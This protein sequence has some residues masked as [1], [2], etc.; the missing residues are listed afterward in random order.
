MLIHAA[1][2][3]CLQLYDNAGLR[4]HILK[5]ALEAESS[6]QNKSMHNKS[7]AVTVPVMCPVLLSFIWYVRG[8]L[9]LPGITMTPANCASDTFGIHSIGSC[10]ALHHSSAA[11]NLSVFSLLRR[12]AVIPT[13]ELCSLNSSSSTWV[14]KCTSFFFSNPAQNSVNVAQ[15]FIFISSLNL[16]PCAL[17][18]SAQHA[19]NLVTWTCS[20]VMFHGKLEQVMSISHATCPSNLN[21]FK[22]PPTNSAWRKILRIGCT[23]FE[24]Y[25]WP[26]SS[27]GM[28]PH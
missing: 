4:W 23:Q 22:M 1:H 9:L 26:A 2:L 11:G 7:I 13:P 18:I 19:R 16:F 21:S 3:E 6:M 17:M 8:I 5:L 12:S 20:I 27:K 10:F 24:T 14:S 25:F 15:G 28:L